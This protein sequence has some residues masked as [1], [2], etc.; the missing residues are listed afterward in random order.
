MGFKGA[1]HRSLMLL[2]ALRGKMLRPVVTLMSYGCCVLAP[3]QS[4]V[5]GTEVIMLHSVMRPAN[6]PKPY[7]LLTALTVMALAARIHGTDKAVLKA[8]YRMLPRLKPQ[9]LSVVLTII[10]APAPL[11][12]M[13]QFVATLPDSILTM[14]LKTPA[15]PMLDAG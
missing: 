4:P 6:S 15:L 14:K 3:A 2:Q 7:C 10:N 12:H 13:N 8:G 9:Y 1:T 5:S 11:A